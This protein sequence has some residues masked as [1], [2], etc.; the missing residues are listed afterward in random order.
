MK[1]KEKLSPSPLVFYKTKDLNSDL[2]VKITMKNNEKEN[3]QPPPPQQNKQIWAG[4]G[5]DWPLSFPGIRPPA[6]PKG[7][8]LYYFEISIFAD[9][10]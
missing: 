9:G 4:G 7:P 10:P 3:K 6:D 8:P 5:G 2:K 1:R